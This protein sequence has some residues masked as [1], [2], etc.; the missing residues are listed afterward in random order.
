MSA[1]AVVDLSW[2]T[3]NVALLGSSAPPLP[4]VLRADILSAMS[5]RHME[6]IIVSCQ[7]NE[8][9]EKD[10]SIKTCSETALVT[11]QKVT[12]EADTGSEP[13]SVCLQQ[14]TQHHE[15]SVP[16]SLSHEH[17][18]QVR[19]ARTAEGPL[20]ELMQECFG[21]TDFKLFQLPVIQQ[22]M[23]VRF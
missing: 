3:N 7:P 12:A 16:G 13:T 21:Y 8:V 10:E 18:S 11:Q 5:S 17:R 15:G 23:M 22:V 2:C 4:R 9:P 19:P 20:R 6:G 14:M 1:Q